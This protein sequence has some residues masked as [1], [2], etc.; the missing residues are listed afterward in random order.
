MGNLNCIKFLEDTPWFYMSNDNLPKEWAKTT[1]GEIHLDL[2]QS[3]NPS[4]MPDQL[5]ELYS[6]P[7]FATGKPEITRGNNIGSSKRIIQNEAVL[8]CKINPRINRIWVVE[9]HTD[10]LQIASTEWLPFFFIQGLE[11]KYLCYFLKQH[12]LRD[13]LASNVSGVGGSLMRIKP[14]T[15]A[16]YPFLIAPSPRTTSHRRQNRRAFHQTRCGQRGTLAGESAIETLSSVCLESSHGRQAD[17]RLAEE[18]WER[19]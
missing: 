13:F 5:F 3:I 18:A 4:K 14:T 16:N 11:P 7:S 19:G 6:V 9:N 15:F 12:R 8:L 10:Y 1:L 2:S 17:G